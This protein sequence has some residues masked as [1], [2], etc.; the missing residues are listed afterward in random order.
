[1]VKKE[2]FDRSDIRKLNAISVLNQLRRQGEL[3]RAQIANQ[4]GLTRATVSSIV[5]DLIDSSLVKE[6]AFTEGVTGRPGLLLKLNPDCGCMIGVEIDLDRISVIVADLG[7]GVIW[8]AG[9][10]IEVAIRPEKCLSMAEELVMEGLSRGKKRG[11]DCFGICVAWAGLVNRYAGELSYGPTFGWEHVPLKSTWEKRFNVPV[12]VENEA[13]AGAMG[14]F[15]FGPTEGTLNLIYL[16][17][18]YGLAAGVFMD[19]VLLRGQNGYAGQVGH[20]SFADNQIVCGCG[21]T[22]CWVTEVGARAV[23]RKLADIGL[24][25]PSNDAADIVKSI[26]DLLQSGD[27]RVKSV[28]E[29]VGR[30]IG[31]GLAPLVQTFDPSHVIIGGRLGRLLKHAE[32]AI[33]KG[34]EEEV[35]PQMSDV[36]QISVSNSHE[37]QLM[38]CLATV[39][40]AVMKNPPIIAKG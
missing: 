10:G 17:I 35:L 21:K 16:S 11:L 5:S 13:H 26:D 30:Q 8:E 31:R 18:G 37:D 4:L 19:G 39:F 14:A 36:L 23:L 22:G 33:R 9:V 27:A 40:D 32:P 29:S 15:H 20:S 1:M 7:Q 3:S 34:W 25:L 6:T 24:N 12:F 2:R 38:G 28:L